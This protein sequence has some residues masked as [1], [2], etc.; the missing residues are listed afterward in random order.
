MSAPGWYPDPTGADGLRYWDG[1]QW[2]ANTSPAPSDAP[3]SYTSAGQQQPD[4]AWQQGPQS[5]PAAMPPPAPDGRGNL[6]LWVAFGVVLAMI[7]GLGSWLLFF[8]QDPSSTPSP[9][10]ASTTTQAVEPT[11][12]SVEPTTPEPTV[13]PS[14]EP[15]TDPSAAP[16]S[17]GP[18]PEAGALIDPVA[19]CPATA[20]DAIGVLDGDGRYTS[21]GGFSV[22]AAEGFSPAPVQYPWI[23]QSNSQTKIYDGNWMAAV[24]VGTLRAEDGFAETA[25]S[26]IAMVAC[27]LGSDFYEGHASQATVV[28]SARA[29]DGDAVA[30]SV[31]VGVEGVSGISSDLVYVMTVFEGGALHVLVATVPNDDSDG[32]TAVGDA[33]KD[34]RFG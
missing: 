21:G 23:H 2:T 13:D 4:A 25:P 16:P 32:I 6:W 33:V 29:P 7:I 11:D 18:P 9:T 1:Q 30:M 10:P 15:T 26:A 28:Q 27:M 14:E 5:G 24:T 31:E 17:M 34:V 8:R 12:P 3:S 19:N 22:A 20:T